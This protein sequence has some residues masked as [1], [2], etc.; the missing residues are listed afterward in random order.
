ML[1]WLSAGNLRL[2]MSQW[3]S[4][5]TP[6]VVS[7]VHFV[8]YVCLRCVSCTDNPCCRHQLLK[9]YNLILFLGERPTQQSFFCCENILFYYYLGLLHTFM[10][11]GAASWLLST[12][13]GGSV[14][15]LK[16][17][18]HNIFSLWCW[19]AH[20]RV[21]PCLDQKHALLFIQGDFIT[22]STMR[23][24]AVIAEMKA[25]VSSP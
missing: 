15:F 14:D 3:I 4:H 20:K 24:S 23:T 12:D 9:V 5:R 1:L 7:S 18:S 8:P 21:F 17:W 16:R 19:R 13:W 25:A 6:T 22:S 11:W 10:G 2:Q